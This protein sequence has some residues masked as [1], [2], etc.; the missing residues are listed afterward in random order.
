ML[1]QSQLS[2]LVSHI[3]WDW[4]KCVWRVFFFS[5]ALTVQKTVWSSECWKLEKNNICEKLHFVPRW[6]S[7]SQ[8]EEYKKVFLCERGL[9][10][11]TE[12]YLLFILKVKMESEAGKMIFG[13]RGRD[14][15]SSSAKL[16]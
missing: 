16:F 1:Y 5:T 4:G 15:D 11:H 7:V 6:N 13:G 2:F 8:G 12:Q 14:K 10:F 9:M 3:L